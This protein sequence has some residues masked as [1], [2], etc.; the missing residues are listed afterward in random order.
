M[1][2]VSEMYAILLPNNALYLWFGKI[3]IDTKS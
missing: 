1:A 3:R 2:E